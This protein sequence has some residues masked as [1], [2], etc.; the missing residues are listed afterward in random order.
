LPGG[1]QALDHVGD[2]G[3]G[4]KADLE[5]GL[6]CLFG[7]FA[8]DDEGHIDGPTLVDAA[9]NDKTIG[10]RPQGQFPHARGQDDIK[11]RNLFLPAGIHLIEPGESTAA[12]QALGIVDH[13]RGASPHQ[14]WEHLPEAG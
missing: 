12:F 14:E 9:A 7:K 8:L 1:S 13:R 11:E 4:I 6:A 3:T 10:V 5:I 2:H